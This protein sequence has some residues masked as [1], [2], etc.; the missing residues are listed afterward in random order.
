MLI[1]LDKS[2]TFLT[3]L[4]SVSSN[5]SVN[6][7]NNE[8]KMSTV[9]DSAR[10]AWSQKVFNV[11]MRCLASRKFSSARRSSGLSKI[12]AICSVMVSIRPSV[13]SASSRY[14]TDD[15]PSL[16]PMAR[17]FWIFFR[18]S[19]LREASL[20][21]MLDIVI[22]MSSGPFAGTGSS[23]SS[24]GT[25]CDKWEGTCPFVGCGAGSARAA[26]AREKLER[27]LAN[28]EGPGRRLFGRPI[29]VGEVGL[30]GG[31]R[32]DGDAG[33]GNEGAAAAGE[34]GLAS[35]EGPATDGLP[36]RG[37]APKREV[38]AG[39]PGRGIPPASRVT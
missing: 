27:G 23:S 16:G 34:A 8:V 31:C 36:G 21:S 25:G 11:C 39:D 18:A 35:L 32:R 3:G 22:V 15:G 14:C 24:T 2:F 10:K 1:N 4:S 6:S 37:I 30:L 13:C 9:S 26:A 29:P 5:R 12:C 38:P 19:T 33:R 17:I 7:S 20:L 28:R